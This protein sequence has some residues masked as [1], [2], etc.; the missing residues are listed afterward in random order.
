[1][2]S[3]KNKR[4]FISHSSENKDIV[5]QFCAF[6]IR[7]G[8]PESDIFCSSIVGQGVN[9]GEKLNDKIAEAINQSSLLVYL[10]SNDFINSEYCM[11]EL[12]SG[13]YLSQKEGKVCYYLVLPDIE[14]C[15]IKGFVN[16]KIDRITIIDKSC[17][18]NLVLLSENLCGALDIAQPKASSTVSAVNTFLRAIDIP[19]KHLGEFKQLRISAVAK[20][21]AAERETKK[22]IAEVEYYKQIS[23]R[24]AENYSD[25]LMVEL[26]TIQRSMRMLVGRNGISPRKFYFLEKSFWFDNINRYEELLEILGEENTTDYMELMLATVY[27]ANGNSDKAYEHIKKYAQLQFLAPFYFDFSYF[28][29]NYKGTMQEVIDIYKEK[30][31]HEKEGYMKDQYVDAIRALEKREE[32]IAKKSHV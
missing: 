24:N 27:S 30:L 16:S 4:V 1:M 15:E 21:I 13:W 23:Y 18:D 9:N 7:L 32:R 5:E 14:L 10:I 19:L 2:E 11:Q 8:I 31:S 20:D 26:Q 25:P 29:K 28:F 17:S 6:L 22:L 3:Q 12:G